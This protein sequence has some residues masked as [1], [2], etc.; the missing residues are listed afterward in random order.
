MTVSGPYNQGENEIASS[1]I[2]N[3]EYF[4]RA[5]FEVRF[6]TP[7]LAA[8]WIWRAELGPEGRGLVE[9]RSIQPLAA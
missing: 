7:G 6:T 2:E 8:F 5:M 4:V 1:S 3:P 9:V